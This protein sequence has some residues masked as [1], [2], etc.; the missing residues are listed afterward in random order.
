M[1]KYELDPDVNAGIDQAVADW[2]RFCEQRPSA[3][4]GVLCRRCRFL[5]WVFGR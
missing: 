5:A 3:R 4:L 1:R 2:C